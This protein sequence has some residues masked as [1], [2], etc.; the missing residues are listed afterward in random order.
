[1][2]YKTLRIAFLMIIIL[3]LAQF[4]CTA[5]PSYWGYTGLILT[6]TADTLPQYGF[7]LGASFIDSD[8]YDSAFYSG[9]VG[10]AA[11]LEIGGTVFVPDGGDSKTIF[12]AKYRVMNEN[13]ALPAVAIGISDATDELDATP[14][15]VL[16]KS[17]AFGTES[18][19]SPRLHIGVGGGG[20]DGLFGGI[21]TSFGPK[22]I[23]MA[24]YDTE[25]V[26]FGVQFAVNKEF[27]IHADSI[28]GDNFGLGI[29]FNSGL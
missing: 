11:G 25:D 5:T 1:M 17:L 2:Y 18:L 14:Y 9:N 4:A 22:T 7:N 29:S 26:N 28:T 24:E 16:S 23:L 13:L 10:I 12:N 27:R 19:I 15:V 21:S 8:S 20:L 6:P 3:V